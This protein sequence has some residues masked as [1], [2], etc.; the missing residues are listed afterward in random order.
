MAHCAS[1]YLLINSITRSKSVAG[2]SLKTQYLYTLVYLTRYVDLIYGPKGSLYNFIM[3]IV[4][5]STSIYIIHL[6]TQ[7][8]KPTHNPNI[9]TFKVE[10]ILGGCFVTSLILNLQFSFTEIVWAFSIWLESVAILPQLFMITRTGEAE[11]LT[12][13]YIFALGIYRG[14]YILNWAWKWAVGA[15]F[16]WVSVF[17]GIIQT[18]LYSDFF[19]VY[20][21]RVMKGKKFELPV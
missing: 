17:A 4:Y 1:I 2:I 6:M 3:K 20:Y 19:W 10:Y 7:K 12:T 15:P 11:S 8:Y 16:D 14:L 18:G 13:H 9:D 21:T 5:I